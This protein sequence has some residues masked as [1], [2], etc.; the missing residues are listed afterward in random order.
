MTDEHTHTARLLWG[1]HPQPTRG[2]KPKL[3]LR[4]IARAGIG[5]AD[6]E[7]LPAVSMQRL[8]AELGVTKMALYRYVP[9]RAELVALMLEEA[10]GPY[11][12]P[13]APPG[14][15][16]EELDHWARR[17]LEVFCRHPWAAEVAVRPR[18]MGPA[19]LGWMEYAVSALDGTALTGAERLDA[20][21]LLAG[22]V[23]AT[24]QHVRAA[25]PVGSPEAQLGSLLAE[26]LG[27]HAERFPALCA[28]FASV[29][30]SGGGD[31]AWEFGLRS[32]LDGL[33]ALIEHDGD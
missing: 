5:I 9:G 27:A 14:G 33:A 17:L 23:R 31:Q 12:A 25:G 32:I 10:V 2:P 21:V 6:A 8:A 1:P 4:S 7:N 28:A 20:V 24:A 30:E 16:R 18:V 26:L 19:E 11:P 22:H 13:D 3:D 15:W 29:G